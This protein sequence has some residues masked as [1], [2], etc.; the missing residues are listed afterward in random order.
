MNQVLLSGVDI[1]IIVAYLC[2]LVFIGLYLKKRA[3]RNLESYLLGGKSLP[4]YMLG[5]SNA[6]GMFDISGTVWLVAITVLY[7]IKSIYMPWVWPVFNQIFLMVY[8]SAW[9]RRSNCSTGAEWIGFRFGQD[10]GAQISHAIIVIFAVINCLGMLAYGFI[11]LGKF[12]E[13]FLP[14]K[15]IFPF[16]MEVPDAYVPH[17]WGIVFTL[18]A[19]FYALLGGMMSIVWADVGQY[20][21]MTI[22]AITIGIIAMIHLTPENFTNLLPDGWMSAGITQNLGIRWEGAMAEFNGE[23]GQSI[24]QIFSFFFGMVLLKGFLTSVAGPAPTYDMQKILSTKSPKEASMMSGFVTVVLMPVR[25]MMIAGI[26]VLGI[27]LFKDILPE[28]R[29]ASGALD[30]ELILP[31]V[32]KHHWIPVGLTGIVVAGLLAAFMSTF[33]GT[34]N[35]AQ[36]YIV[37]DIYIKYFKPKATPKQATNANYIVG[38]VVVIISI[39]LGVAAKNV[40]QMLQWVTGALYGSYIAANILKWHWWRFNSSGFAWGMAAGLIPALI[41][42]LV[43]PVFKESFPEYAM[44]AEPLYYFPIILL[45]S[46]IGCI[47]GTYSAPPTEEGALK[48]FYQKTRPWGFWKPIAEKVKADDPTFMENKNFARDMVNVIVGIVWQTCLVA[49]PIYL[50]CKEFTYAGIGLMVVIVCSV[51]LYTNWYKRLE[52]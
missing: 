27:I 32:V 24:Y 33:A 35:A 8:L 29:N 30:A 38:I 23:I 10:K 7:G 13:I 22:A 36:A 21:I 26:A 52:D 5:L 19:V 34:L 11:G 18:F 15:T 51:L 25:Y 9:L 31:A 20:I 6:S 1:A 43:A 17:I 39:F 50:V 48:N 37:N 14:L 16:L 28:I 4:W 12:I 41:L 2:F 42:P 45:F 49:A 46:I 3:S 40:D 44:W 47:I